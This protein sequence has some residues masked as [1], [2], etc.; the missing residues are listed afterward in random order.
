MYLRRLNGLFGPKI[1]IKAAVAAMFAAGIAGT[2]LAHSESELRI[3]ASKPVLTYAD[4]VSQTRKLASHRSELVAAVVG[5][6]V[7]LSL[8]P[9]GSRSDLF[10]A[11]KQDD[12]GFT[13]RSKAR[14]FKS[15]VVVATIVDYEPG[16]D[17]GDFYTLDRCGR[18]K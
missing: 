10:F 11:D 16:S 8:E 7:R 5:R 15:G 13:C 18:A 1:V 9:F 4:L 17:A 12:V 3:T 2:A 6:R 14:G